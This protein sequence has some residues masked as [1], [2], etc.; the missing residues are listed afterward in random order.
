MSGAV[1]K[2]DV[3]AAFQ[4]LLLHFGN[5]HRARE[6]LEAAIRTN[7]VRLYDGDDIIDPGFFATDLCVRTKLAKE[8][9]WSASVWPT[10]IGLAKPLSEYSWAVAEP[11]IDAMIKPPMKPKQWLAEAM[12][13][14]R[15]A[16]ESITD[17]AR[18][19]VPEM[20]AAADAARVTRALERR[21]IENYL[22]VLNY[23]GKIRRTKF[24]YLCI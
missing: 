17:A 1:A 24:A 13:P 6:R 19:L 23:S 2:I 16:S 9:R 10:R 15:Q 7:D 11:D 12:K 20:K 4:R 5:G 3:G 18:N 14:H 8:G 22:R 21:S